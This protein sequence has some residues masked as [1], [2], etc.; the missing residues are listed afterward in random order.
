MRAW[1]SL[2]C[3]LPLLGCAGLPEDEDRCRARPGESSVDFDCTTADGWSDEALDE[4][5]EDMERRRP[6]GRP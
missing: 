5:E 2:V 4:A 3:L 6:S 1:L